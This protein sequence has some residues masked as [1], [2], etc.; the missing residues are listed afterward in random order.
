MNWGFKLT[1]FRANNALDCDPVQPMEPTPPV[2]LSTSLSSHALWP[3]ADNNNNNIAR[4]WSMWTVIMI[5]GRV[6]FAR[7]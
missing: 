7:N 1:C 5:A 3:P 4:I 6:E 2:L